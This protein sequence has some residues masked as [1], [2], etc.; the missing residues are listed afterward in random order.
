[1]QR[2]FENRFIATAVMR[3][4]EGAASRVID[5]NSSRGCHFAY[6]V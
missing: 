3:W 5:K 1:M 2:G 4:T 6:Y